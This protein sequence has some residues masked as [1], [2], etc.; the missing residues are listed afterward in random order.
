[1]KYW[2]AHDGRVVKNDYTGKPWS[3]DRV[4]TAKKYAILS[5]FTN[6]RI[7]EKKS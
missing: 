7:T 2:L 6:Y 4:S 3:F 5:H 1:M